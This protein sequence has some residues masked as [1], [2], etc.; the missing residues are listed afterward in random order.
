MKDWHVYIE[1]KDYS[2]KRNIYVSILDDATGD[3]SFVPPVGEAVALAIGDDPEPTF[4]D[5]GR[6]RRA[7]SLLQAFLDAAW[8]YGLRP[9]GFKDH[10]SE[11]TATRYHLEDMRALAKV[12]PR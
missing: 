2:S 10:T 8:E 6:G 5:V 7:D 12:P 1:D 11:L 9:K 4:V 3:R